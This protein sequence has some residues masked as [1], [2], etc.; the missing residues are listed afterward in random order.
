MTIL[1][2]QQQAKKYENPPITV[3]G[4]LS[5]IRDNLPNYSNEQF[6]FSRIADGNGT[7]GLDAVS[8]IPRGLRDTNILALG[9]IEYSHKNSVELSQEDKTISGQA[10]QT[11]QT[12]SLSEFQGIPQ[13]V[14][15]CTL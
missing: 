3:T 5:D 12:F 15:A 11:F 6:N 9:L 13:I 10:L 14:G 2:R 1:P 7:S 8:R 4:R